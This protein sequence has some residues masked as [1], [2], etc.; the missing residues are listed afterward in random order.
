VFVFLAILQVK[1]CYAKVKTTVL[2]KLIQ[3]FNSFS[4]I[5]PTLTLLVIHFSSKPTNRGWGGEGNRSIIIHRQLVALINYIIKFLYDISKAAGPK[6][7]FS[8][9]LYMYTA[10]YA[11]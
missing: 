1:E 3:S 11:V 4:N 2:Q 9:I 10:M 5:D 8:D 7:N 6:Y